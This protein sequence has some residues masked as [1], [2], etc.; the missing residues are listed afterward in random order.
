MRSH[1]HDQILHVLE[2]GYRFFIIEASDNSQSHFGIDV[3]AHGVGLYWAIHLVKL[4]IMPLKDSNCR[5]QPILKTDRSIG[6]ISYP[7][8]SQDTY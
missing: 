1:G 8:V 4:V 6:N 3:K 7:D 2:D 5:Q